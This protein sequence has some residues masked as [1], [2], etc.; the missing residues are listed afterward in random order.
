MFLIYYFLDF[1]PILFE[2]VHPHV[3]WFAPGTT[4]LYF[5]G[6]WFSFSLSFQMPPKQ[7][8]RKAAPLA[9]RKRSKRQSTQ[10][11]ATAVVQRSEAG[12]PRDQSD[13]G[14]PAHSQPEL[15]VGN[16]GPSQDVLPVLSSDIL[17]QIAARVTHEVTSKLAP[18]LPISH[19]TSQPPSAPGPSHPLVAQVNAQNTVPVPAQ[20]AS[21]SEQPTD[22]APVQPPSLAP[23]Q[24]LSSP[25]SVE[26]RLS[27]V[28]VCSLGTAAVTS[29]VNSIHS[30]LTGELNPP[31]S[32]PSSLFTSSALPVDARVSEKLK[33]KIWANEYIDFGSLLVNPLFENKYHVTFQ[34]PPRGL[35]PSLSLESV[36]KPKRINSIE[37]WDKAFRIFVGVFTQRYPHEAPC[38]MKYSEI[39][40]DLAVRGQ[41]WRF[42]DENFR[43]LRQSNVSSYSWGHV[44]WEL[45]LRSQP[46][47]GRQ[48]TIDQS[49]VP[50]QSRSGPYLHIPRGFCYK[51]HKGVACSGCAFKHTCFKCDGTH[52]ASSCNFRPSPDRRPTKS[53]PSTAKSANPSTN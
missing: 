36:V 6:S 38:L 1:S 18:L 50:S 11:V 32:L 31:S 29:S 2:G 7:T 10:H 53:V 20:P 41:N 25:S 12:V 52:R 30:H 39:V 28:P 16:N 4:S 40:H 51:F 42:Y 5:E 43:F 8:K 17:N 44:N 45:W 3:Q 47:Q 15:P 49:S 46:Y 21:A 13:G 37:V 34:N 35:T 22:L 9:T 14:S 27:E 33:S 23:T 26:P 24:Q 19:S 48:R